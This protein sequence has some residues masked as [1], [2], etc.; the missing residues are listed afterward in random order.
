MHVLGSS[1]TIQ[2]VI[3]KVKT[4][5]NLLSEFLR[6][7]NI[8][9]HFPGQVLNFLIGNS[10]QK[11]FKAACFYEPTENQNKTQFV[12]QKQNTMQQ[13]AL[14]HLSGYILYLDKADNMKICKEFFRS[15][16][17]HCLHLMKTSAIVVF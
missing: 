17:F 15:R 4:F 11:I 7:D 5:L 13:D 1:F 14:M 2:W 16:L 6:Y 8:L 9:R 3:P 10:P 12:W